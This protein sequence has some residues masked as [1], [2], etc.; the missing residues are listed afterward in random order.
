VIF[1]NAYGICNFWLHFSL[2]PWVSV[3]GMPSRR[4]AECSQTAVAGNGGETTSNRKPLQNSSLYK[5]LLMP[6]KKEYVVYQQKKVGV[7]K[8]NSTRNAVVV[9]PLQYSRQQ[10]VW[11]IQNHAKKKSQPMKVMHRQPRK[12]TVEK[13]S[14]TLTDLPFVTHD[15]KP[16]ICNK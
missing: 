16:K 13:C 11:K 14:A 7:T 10:K 4:N 6:I 3:Y 8:N 2:L 15:R 12:I 1:L 9:S 5:S